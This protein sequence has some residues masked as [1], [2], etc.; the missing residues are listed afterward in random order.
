MPSFYIIGA[1]ML[2]G[3]ALLGVASARLKLPSSIVL[4][5][6]GS[7][8]SFVPGVPALTIDPQVVLLLFLPPLLYSSGVGMSWRGFHAN[9]RPILLL[10]IGC[11]IFTAA[12][13]A[14]VG[15]MLLGMSWAVAFVLGAVVSPPDAVAPMAIMRRLTVPNRIGLILEGEG[16]VN[17]ATAL[18]LFA[19]AVE[20]VSAGRVS[21]VSALG[22]LVAVIVGEVLWGA[23]IGALALRIRRW[24]AEPEAEIILALLTPYLA[25]WPPHALG[26]SGV[27]A[28]VSA[29]LFV[30]RFGPKF[31]A[32]ATRLQGFFVWGLINHAVEALLFLL[33][34]LQAREI[35][36]ALQGWERPLIAAA[37]VTALTLAIRFVWVFPR[38]I[39]R[40][41]CRG[42][43][44]RAIR[45][46]RGRFRR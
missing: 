21:L 37:S 10:A 9:L 35:V 34:G 31:I 39:C 38:P 40:A 19:F 46:R 18:I 25:F 28:A 6:V 7:L 1:L 17:D 11:V 43:S 27:L 26:G 12:A 8:V 36:A 3:I 24:A 15:H 22:N 32:P 30:S 16:L 44:A 33:V 41:G 23:A 5:V 45:R 20:A 2:L 29:G 14:V 4:V 13:V 42:A